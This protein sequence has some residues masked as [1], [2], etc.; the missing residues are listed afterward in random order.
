[1]VWLLFAAGCG[2]LG[3][4]T[5]GSTDAAGDGLLDDS[6]LADTTSFDAR[7]CAG[8]THT[9]TDNFDDNMR[10]VALWGNAYTDNLSG[11]AETGGRVVITLGANSAN[12]WA[13]YVTTTGYQLK[14]DRVFVEVPQISAS[15]TN[16]MLMAAT[17]TTFNDG[18]SIESE[19]GRLEFRKRVAGSIID[20]ADL[21]YNAV[22][23]RW[24]QLTET[25]GRTYWQLSRDGVSWITWYQ[26]PSAASTTAFITLVAGTN[27]AQATPGT[28]IFDNLNGGG[29]QPDCP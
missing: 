21:P 7:P 28:A 23:H 29:A 27:A 12:D 20:L 5:T 22:E 4:G 11:Y 19:T 25:N 3:F 14:D 6:V 16:T 8:T 24:W 1:M 10:N 18:P 13:G 17:S 2:R 26:E 9:I 15:G